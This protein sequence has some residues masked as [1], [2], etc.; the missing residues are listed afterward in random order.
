MR[1]WAIVLLAQPMRIE[2]QL[3]SQESVNGAVAAAKHP[4]P[5]L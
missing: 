4:A 3:T 2:G 5:Y 1:D